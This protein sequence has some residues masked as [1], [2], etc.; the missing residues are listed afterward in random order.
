MRRDREVL[1]VR[2]A[3]PRGFETAS[4]NRQHPG[5]DRIARDTA[6]LPSRARTVVVCSPGCVTPLDARRPSTTPATGPSGRRPPAAR[7]S[8]A[9]SAGPRK[10]RGATHSRGRAGRSPR[11]RHRRGLGHRHWRSARGSVIP[12]G[13]GTRKRPGPPWAGSRP[14]ADATS[15]PSRRRGRSARASTRRRT[16][17]AATEKGLTGTS[18]TSSYA[19]RRPSGRP[20]ICHTSREAQIERLRAQ[21]AEL[22]ARVTDR[23]ATIEELRSRSSDCPDSP[24]STTRSARSRPPSRRHP[25]SW[26]PSLAPGPPSSVL[27]ADDRQGQPSQSEFRAKGQQ[28]AG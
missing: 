13:P 16:A 25:P 5:P 28:R 14:A 17:T 3:G 15:R 2:A 7:S 19:A 6:W 20:G 10:P 1:R 11:R 18:A 21:T 26:Q 4:G 22:K 24:P 23:D 27:T 9:R 8:S 12:T